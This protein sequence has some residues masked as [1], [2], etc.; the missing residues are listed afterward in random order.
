M[1]I[2][3]KIKELKDQLKILEKEEQKSPKIEN[4]VFSGGSTKGLSYIGVLTALREYGMLTDIKEVVGTSIG[5]LMGLFIVLK[6]RPE[7][8]IEFITPLDFNN[9]H[10]INSDSIITLVNDYGLDRGDNITV[11]FK[12]FIEYCFPYLVGEKISK[13]R[14][15][16]DITFMD[17]WDYNPIKLTLVGSRVYSS[18]VK[19]EFYNYVETPQ[20][21]VLEALKITTSIPPIFCPVKGDNCHLLDGGLTNNF[22]I[23][24]FDQKGDDNKIEKTLGFLCNDELNN[25]SNQ[26][27]N[28]IE[29]YKS[30][31]SFLINR[32]THEKYQKYKDN[33]IL[34]QPRLDIFNFNLEV[35]KKIETINLGYQLTKQY[36]E[37]NKFQIKEDKYQ[38]KILD[39]KQMIQD[40]QNKILNQNLKSKN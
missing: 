34:I 5:G 19:T 16:E 10:G 13:R 31:I 39:T 3:Q 6:F 12:L 24:Y 8:L 7:D 35:N 2:S 14:K 15:P 33:I 40:Y 26:C 17:L 1:N 38:W 20:M 22:P 36:L 30:I 9:L 11:F 21:S 25:Q 4:L 27:Q 28:V 23:D 29:L 18:N 32:D 37:M